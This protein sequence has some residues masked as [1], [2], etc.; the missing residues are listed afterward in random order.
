MSW[1]LEFRHLEIQG[2]GIYRR[3]PL[4]EERVH[5]S[6]SILPLG[7]HRARLLTVSPFLICFIVR[8]E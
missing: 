8:A 6:G 1:G 4:E 5:Q 3:E 2:N 7:Q